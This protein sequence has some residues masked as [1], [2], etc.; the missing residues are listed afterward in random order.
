MESMH[1]IA[2]RA[3]DQI[4]SAARTQPGDSAALAQHA[5]ALLGIGPEIIEEFCNTLYSHE[6]IAQLFTEDDRP[7]LEKE[8]QG[9]WE[10]T[11]RGPFDDDYWAWMALIGLTQVVRRISNPMIVSMANFLSSSIAARADRITGE[12]EEKQLVSD[13]FRR[14]ISTAAAVISWGYEYAV[15]SSLYEVAGM[16]EALL[17]R[18][19]EQEVSEALAAAKGSVGR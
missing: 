8:L 4:P 1:E 11:V 6:A 13:A 7:A 14:V 2:R 19:C 16:P 15:R 18:L 9:W 5:E 10:R 17:E 3:I 12:E